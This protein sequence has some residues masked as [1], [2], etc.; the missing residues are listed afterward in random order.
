MKSRLPLFALP[1]L[2]L[3]A[4]KLPEHRQEFYA[5][6]TLKERF[7]VYEKDG[8]EVMDGLY[9]SFYPNGRREVE[10]LY[11]DGSAVTKTYYSERGT[12][13]GTVNIASLPEP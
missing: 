5:N 7:W 4:C 10:I 9:I 3:A 2:V 11:R 6:G 13:Q 12:M 1:L 8:R